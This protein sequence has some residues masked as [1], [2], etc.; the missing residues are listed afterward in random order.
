MA[1]P[2]SI[3]VTAHTH[4]LTEGYFA[5]KTLGRAQIKGVEEP[6][7]HLRS[8]G[9]WPLRTRLQVAARR[10]TDAVCRAPERDGAVATGA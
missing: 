10:G 2:G 1:T 3:L 7:Q 4:K 6:L 8:A 5:F 9:G